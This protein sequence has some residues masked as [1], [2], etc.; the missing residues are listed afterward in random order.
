M[1]GQ[2]KESL[3]N[4]NRDTEKV[5]LQIAVV[6]E[7]APVYLSDSEVLS[8]LKE[9]VSKLGITSIKEKGK[10]M[11]VVSKDLKGKADMGKVNKLIVEILS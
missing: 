8:Y 11:G 6:N 4:A 1:L 3:L 9:T 10:L 5:D 7:F 2:E